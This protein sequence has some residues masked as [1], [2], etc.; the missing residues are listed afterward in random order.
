MPAGPSSTSSTTAVKCFGG[1]D[2]GVDLSPTGGT[3]GYT[4]LWSNN[5]TTQDLSNVSSG[6]YSVTIT[7]ANNC[8]TTVSATVS[9]P[10]TALG[11][12]S[13]TTAVS[14]FGG[15]D[16]GV[17]L[18][19]TG[20]TPGYTYLWSNN[21]T[22]QDLSNVSSDTYSVTITDANNCQTTVSATVSQ[23]TTALGASSSTTAVKCFGGSD[24]GVD[25]SPTGGT[26]GYTYLWSNNATTQDLSNVATGTYSVTITDANNCQTTVSAT[27]S[28]PAL[29][30]DA[31]SSTTAV[32]CFGGSDGG[33]DLSPTGGTPGYT[34]LWS[35]NATTQDLSNVA[36]G[37]YSVTITDANNCQTTVSAT[38]S[39]PT[40][41]LGASSSTT[42]V[43]CFGGSD[44]GVDLSPTGGTPGYTYLWEQQCYYP[45]FE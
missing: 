20:G 7:D 39:Q 42:A 12:S 13:S 44:G 31:S 15:S 35:N 37:T 28:Q 5:A 24:G 27:V 3:P 36:T 32:S 45:R 18:S 22:T 29:A 21:A 11:A 25:L 23:P 30:L 19:P 38:V 33:V 8:Q 34:Y 2:G 4:Y 1:S 10:T 43:K 14:C 16:G 6:T 40:T 9:Q 41:A 26:P 17:D